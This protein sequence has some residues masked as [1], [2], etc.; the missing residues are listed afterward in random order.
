MT[1][2]AVFWDMDGTLIDS[3]PYWHEGEFAIAKR[4]GGT[5]SEALGWQMSGTALSLCAR[6]MREMGTDLPEERI[7][8]LMVDYVARRES[9][10]MPWTD[11]VLSVLKSLVKAG[12][13]SVLVTSSPRT[14][15]EV[16][17]RQAPE[18]AFSAFVCGDDGLPSKPDPAPYEHAAELLGIAH[19]DIKECIALEDSP[20]GLQSA[21]A[22]GATTIAVTGF[23]RAD[24]R[25]QHQFASIRDYVGIDATVLEN[26]VTARTRQGNKL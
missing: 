22:S 15:A 7:A 14:L 17:V 18:G 24:V 23:T 21:V 26:F 19:D 11:G 16:V 5:W 20:S 3:E 8:E 2:R 25:E 4:F 6:K 12:V 10:T 13:P 1:L 9:E